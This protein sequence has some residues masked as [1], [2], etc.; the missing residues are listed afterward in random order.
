MKPSPKHSLVSED[1]APTAWQVAHY[2][3]F[4]KIGHGAASAWR[5]AKILDRFEDEENAGRVKIEAHAEEASYFDVY[6]EPDDPKEREEIE[7]ALE[8]NGCFVVASYS[9]CSE[10][11]SWTIADSIGMCVF[12]RVC[13][14]F[15]NFYVIDLMDAALRAL[16]TRHAITV[17]S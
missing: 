5:A 12:S 11:E 3:R 14:P 8:L 6:G 16:E 1:G 9:R 15:D 13:D 2:K 17:R 10:C 4:R 7:R